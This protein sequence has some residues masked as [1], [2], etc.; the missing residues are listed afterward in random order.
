MAGPDQGDTA[1]AAGSDIHGI[2]LPTSLG[3]LAD[4]TP[5]GAGTQRLE[6]V[7]PSPNL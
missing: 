1:L 2:D 6:Q 7:R 5:A 3:E 4:A